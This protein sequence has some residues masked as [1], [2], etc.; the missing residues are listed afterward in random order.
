MTKKVA[1]GKTVTILAKDLGF[2]REEFFDSYD[3]FS[4]FPGCCT[5]G[6]VSGFPSDKSLTDI[7]EEKLGDVKQEPYDYTDFPDVTYDEPEPTFIFPTLAQVKEE[8]FKEFTLALKVLLEDNKRSKAVF[9]TLS[10]QQ[11]IAKGIALKL[12]FKLLGTYTGEEGTI[13]VLAK[14]L[15]LSTR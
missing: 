2:D 7:A 15:R 11:S 5:S 1:K 9:I 4:D 8:L 10:A 12:G 14:G 6:V 3:G 13:S